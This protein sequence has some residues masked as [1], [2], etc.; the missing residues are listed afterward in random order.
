MGN[1]LFSIVIPAYNRERTVSRAI[2]SVLAQTYNPVECI[3]VDDG[4]IDHTKDIVESF[5]KNDVKYIYQ[6]NSGAQYARN[7]GLRHA[8]GKYILF[9]DSDDELLPRCLELVVKCFN[10]DPEL[11]AVYFLTGRNEEGKIEL[12]RNDTLSGRIFKQVLSQGYLTSSSFIAMKREI[13]TNIGEWDPAFPASQD[14]DMCFRVAEK[15]KIGLIP[16]ILGLYWMDAGVG[17]KIGGSPKRVADGWWILWNKYENS[18]YTL[19]GEQTICKHYMECALRYARILDKNMEKECLNK[20][21]YFSSKSISWLF[22]IRLWYY[23]AKGFLSR[24][25]ISMINR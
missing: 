23:R 17:K 10:E 6:K 2:Q 9:L 19:C 25:R 20:I 3:V 13:F 24:F 18:V 21:T 16:E 12:V 1:E 11:G 8:Q 14:D 22:R 7:N 4:S 15:Y 5:Q